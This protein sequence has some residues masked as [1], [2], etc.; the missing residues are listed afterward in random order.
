VSRVERGGDEWRSGREGTAIKAIKI[1]KVYQDLENRGHL[2][3]VHLSRDR[4]AGH[5]SGRRAAGRREHY[6]GLRALEVGLP[7]P[8]FRWLFHP[9]GGASGGCDRRGAVAGTRRGEQGVETSAEAWLSSV[10]SGGRVGG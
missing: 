6:G 8:P 3:E 1:L 7:A 9:R 5:W 4:R 10:G 2:W